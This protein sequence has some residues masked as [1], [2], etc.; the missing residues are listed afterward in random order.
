MV[1]N[2]HSKKGFTLVELSLATVFVA[3]L[4]LMIA[5]ITINVST[6][7]QKG[8][9]LRNINTTGRDLVDDLNRT[10]NAAPLRPLENQWQYFVARNGE[11]AE[12][13]TPVQLGGVFC[14]GRYSYVWNTEYQSR[15]QA[16]PIIIKYKI[17]A[18][19]ENT[20]EPTLVKFSDPNRDACVVA[21]DKGQPS[22]RNF[23]Q[24]TTID[25]SS[26]ILGQ[27]PEEMLSE[28]ELAL[29]L[30]DFAIFPVSQV[31]TTLQTLYTGT[32][33]LGT[34]RGDINIARQNDFCKV[35]AE[36]DPQ[37]LSGDFNYCAVNKFN[38]TAR[39]TGS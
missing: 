29:V 19:S 13:R 36:H 23:D 26:I 21:D 5:T 31:D 1:R 25:L 34:K 39:A 3:V 27:A 30:Y 6:I 7:Y 22:S 10:I 35:D 33:I 12:T 11:D 37:S 15:Q 38:F 32:F 28:S 17:S 16:K 24:N 4:L 20:I 18:E 14:T 9:A 8:L 2:V